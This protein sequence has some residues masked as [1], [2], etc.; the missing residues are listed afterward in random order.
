MTLSNTFE[1]LDEVGREGKVQPL[2][3]QAAMNGHI[4]SMTLSNT[5]ELLDEVGREVLGAR[6]VAH[7]TEQA[8][9]GGRWCKDLMLDLV[10]NAVTV[11]QAADRVVSPRCNTI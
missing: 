11:V 5:F 9:R 8:F 10:H 7:N 2:S 6:H 4:S 3:K 1:L